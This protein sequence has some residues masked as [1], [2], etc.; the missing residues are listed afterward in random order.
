MSLNEIVSSA[1]DTS[2]SVSPTS[3]DDSGGSL[4]IAGIH[5][6]QSPQIMNKTE[7][8]T[9]DTNLPSRY[10]SAT[11]PEQPSDLTPPNTDRLLL[12]TTSYRTPTFFDN[13]PQSDSIVS[14]HIP[15]TVGVYTYNMA[16]PYRCSNI[17]ST[18]EFMSFSS[19]QNPSPYN[20]NYR[21]CD[22]E[23]EPLNLSVN[24]PTHQYYSN[25]CSAGPEQINMAYPWG[26]VSASSYQEWLSSMQQQYQAMGKVRDL[27]ALCARIEY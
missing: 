19:W 6:P 8:L 21:Y 2:S 27:S 14:S 11:T 1:N 18:P 25:H 20:Y 26:G 9:V 7:Q 24:A 15:T 4:S 16:S 17:N 3:L 5:T 10:T 12:A 13:I 23:P 22:S